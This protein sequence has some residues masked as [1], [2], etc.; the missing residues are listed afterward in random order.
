MLRIT[1]RSVTEG[2]AKTCLRVNKSVV[3]FCY[4]NMKRRH[5]K[6]GNRV[7]KLRAKTRISEDGAKSTH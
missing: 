5:I 6:G 3:S 1:L 2:N 7:E 4:Q